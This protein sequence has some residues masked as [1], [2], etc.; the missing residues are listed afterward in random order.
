MGQREFGSLEV[1]IRRPLKCPGRFNT[2]PAPKWDLDGESDRSGVR[3]NA[4]RSP[5]VLVPRLAD[6]VKALAADIDER[7]EGDTGTELLVQLKTDRCALRSLL[8][9]DSAEPAQIL[10]SGSS[11]R[12][13]TVSIW[14]RRGV[15]L[16]AVISSPFQV[17]REPGRGTMFSSLASRPP[18]VSTSSSSS[19]RSK[20]SP[21]SSTG[22]RAETRQTPVESCS[23]RSGSASYSS[24]I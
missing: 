1:D 12:T 17:I 11:R 8:L 3:V 4:A 19:S 14:W 24:T 13:R 7:C 16:S 6:P 20:R 22:I 2:S 10:S 15:A 9:G 21:M 23:A 18:T 5:V